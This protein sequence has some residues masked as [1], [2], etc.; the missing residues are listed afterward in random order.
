LSTAALKSRILA[1]GQTLSKMTGMTVTGDMVNAYRAIGA[2]PPV[3]ARPDRFSLSL[4]STVGSTT[5]T[6]VVRWPAATDIVGVDHYSLKK[7]VGGEWATITS[8]T[9]ALFA[10][11]K[12]RYRADYLYRVRAY[13]QGGNNDAAD[14]ATVDA[15]LHHAETTTLASYGPG[16]STSASGGAVNGALRTSTTAGAEMTFGFTGRSVSIVAPK[17]ASRG[18]FEVYVDGVL[19]ATV[20][21]H[22]TSAA[23]RIVVF[24]QTW[25]EQG[26]HSIR[27]VNLGTAGHPRIDIDAFVVFRTA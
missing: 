20:D 8:S 14:S 7:K 1:N 12:V 4:G 16:W 17:G 19:D 10:R 27:I 23:S 11:T 21:L 5:A 15:R 6:A 25:T 13:D 3:A 18:S 9:E 2:T 24:T 26:T 22:A